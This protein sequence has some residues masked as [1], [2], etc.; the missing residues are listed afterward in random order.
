MRCLFSLALLHL[1]WATPAQV[2]FESPARTGAVAA[3]PFDGSVRTTST[4][5]VDKLSNDSDYSSLLRLLQRAKL[6]PTLNRLN[7]STFFA[8]TNDAIEKHKA[9]NSLWH[10]ALSDDDSP[11][12]DNVHE[13][14][15]QDL[16]YHLLNY[17]ISLPQEESILVTHTLHFPHEHT[18]P[19]THEPPGRP[20]W[21]PQPGG[22]LGGEPQRL[23]VAARESAVYVGVDTFGKGGAKLVKGEVDAGNGILLG[24]DSVLAPPSHLADI[25]GDQSSLSYFQRILTP[26]VKDRLANTSEL[27]LFVPVDS[28]FNA[29]PKYERL[30][31][32][33]DFA[34]DDLQR[35]F[36][37]HA[38]V[39]DRVAYSESFEPAVNLTTLHG[40]TLEVVRAPDK[41]LVSNAEIVQSDIYA[42]NG[43]L[44]TVNSLLVPD[45]ALRL[46]PEKMLLTFNCTTFISLLHSVDLTSLVNN[47]DAKYTILAPA[48]DVITL[49]GNDELPEKGSEELKKLLQYHFLPGKWTPKKLRDATLVETELIEDGLDGGRQVLEVE[50]TDKSKAEADSSEVIRFAG[51]AV[52]DSI[53]VGSALIYFISRPIIPPADSLAVALPS[54][55]LS[56]FLAAVFSADLQDVLKTSVRS[57][58]LIP[59]NDA[60]KR[61]GALVSSRLLSTAG[62]ADLKNTILH[63][64]L[65]GVFYANDLANGSTRTFGTLE[66]S[67]VSLTRASNGS[68]SLAGSGGWRGMSSD[69]WLQNTLSR[70]GVVHELS[71]IL[72]PR[73]VNFT[74]GK[75]VKAATGTT[76]ANLITR[77]GMDWVLN[78]TAPPEDSKWA[79]IRGTGWTLLCPNDDAFKNVNLTALYADSDALE[80]IVAQHLIKTPP[81]TNDMPHDDR[82]LPLEDKEVHATLL[83]PDHEYGDVV[84]RTDNGQLLVGIQ[85]ARGTGA[86]DDWARVIAWGRATTGPGGGSGGVVQIDRLLMPYSAPWWWA[87]GAPAAVGVLGIVIIAGFFALVRLVWRRDTTEATYEPVG[88]FIQ[89][90]DDEEV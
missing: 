72:L 13:Q 71:D 14:L 23:R 31:L 34:A 4:T 33:S 30:Y 5:L 89:D 1:A 39:Q 26:E 49:F 11:L 67:D 38:V 27:T 70:T 82:P 35:I 15:R 81:P 76:M 45:G 80:A 56:A 10:A 12:L 58:L 78:G 90:E 19:P 79:G 32:E 47:T 61:L 53:E 41:V 36:E 2:H 25:I 60:F 63:H 62:K 69:V 77:A 42:A 84:F 43:V 48:D 51:A 9:S 66:G 40:Q 50:V 18:E 64:T 86:R 73:T 22:T 54:L 6:I 59:H 55:D 52:V 75:L 16:L 28:A 21:M 83:S 7:G 46:T 87:Y 74:V 20:P 85:N 88:G 17:S 57:T 44:H 68:L 29:L 24:I 3:A 8:P 37:M 65:E